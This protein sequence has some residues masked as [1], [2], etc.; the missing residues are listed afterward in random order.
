MA[1]IISI[2]VGVVVSVALGALAGHWLV[3]RRLDREVF[4]VVAN[5]RASSLRANSAAATVEAIAAEWPGV[6][7]RVSELD[8]LAHNAAR[9]AQAGQ[10]AGGEALERQKALEQAVVANLNVS[11]M[12]EG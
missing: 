6:L 2:L 12:K 10:Q 4:A 1:I 8:A 9:S 5:A 11:L 7:E 3:F